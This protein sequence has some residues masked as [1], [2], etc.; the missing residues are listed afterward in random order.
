MAL[1]AFKQTSKCLKIDPFQGAVQ[2]VR[3][4]G[5]LVS[6]EKDPTARFPGAKCHDNNFRQCFNSLA[7]I[8]PILEN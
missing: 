8:L 3:F 7:T 4:R 1:R 5:I 2:A 6:A